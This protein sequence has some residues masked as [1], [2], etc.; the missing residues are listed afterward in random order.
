[1]DSKIASVADRFMPSSKA[2]GSAPKIPSTVQNRV[3]IRNPSRVRN[4]RRE[5]RAGSHSKTPLNSVMPRAVA[6][7]GTYPVAPG[8]ELKIGR[9]PGLCDVCLTEPRISGLHATCKFEAG[10]LMVRDEGSNNGT[11]VAGGRIQSYAWVAVPS[12]SAIRFGPIEF[13]VRLE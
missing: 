12:G 8:R 7:P 13:T 4:S 5:L 11:F 6:N 2:K 9:D 1:M 10:Q 3:V